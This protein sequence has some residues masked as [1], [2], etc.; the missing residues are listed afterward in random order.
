MTDHLEPQSLWRILD[1]ARQLGAPIDLETMFTTVVDAACEVLHAER[2]TVFLYDKESDELWS[3]VATG[4]KE[5]RIPATAGIAGQCAQTREPISVPD[6]YAD[7]RFNPEVDKKTGFKTRC[8]VTVPLIASDSQLVGVLQVLNKADGAV[9]NTRD[10]RVAQAF[11]TQCAVA[12][13]RAQLIEHALV[14]ERMERDLAIARDI[15]LNV[16][17]NAMPA[18]TGY[19]LAGWTEPADETGGDIYDVVQLNPHAAMLL[20]ADATGHGVGPALSVTQCRA[21]FRMAMRIGASLSAI[22]SGI[23]QQLTEDLHDNRFITAFFGRLDALKH[24][25]EYVSAG[26]GPLIHFH[27]AT[28]RCSLIEASTIPLGISDTPPIDTPEPVRLQPGDI[29]AL[30]SDGYFEY[31]D[32]KGQ[33][34]GDQRVARTIQQN[35]D[36]PMQDVIA[37]L[38]RDVKLFSQDAPQGDDMTALLIKRLTI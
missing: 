28:N 34:F 27:A 21:M 2:A 14:K 5:I 11:A 23:N 37:A 15:Q 6:C 22:F 18:M 29:F 1:V 4:A 35:Q 3:S 30:L 9:F 10:L 19:D 13:Q 7:K 32:T 16:L 12:L 33:Q 20:L 25:I 17:P 38:N 8:M 26:Q 36:K 24:T 31:A